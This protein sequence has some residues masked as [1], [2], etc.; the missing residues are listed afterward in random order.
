M[1]DNSPAAALETA[2]IS[3]REEEQKRMFKLF[4]DKVVPDL[5]GAM[6]EAQSVK[7]EL[8][9]RG[10]QKCEALS[11]MIESL[12]GA[13]CGIDSIADPEQILGED[14][15]LSFDPVNAL[16]ITP[17]TSSRTAQFIRTRS[18]SRIPRYRFK[19]TAVGLRSGLKPLTRVESRS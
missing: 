18:Q 12:V 8:E 7:E 9:W 6:F 10:S 16:Q 13:V 5:V 2:I 3:V 14:E 11:R 4:R 19:G 1:D 17:N 15:H